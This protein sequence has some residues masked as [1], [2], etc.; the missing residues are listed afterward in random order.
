ML[1]QCQEVPE[2]NKA[3]R[4]RQHIIIQLMKEHSCL[5]FDIIHMEASARPCSDNRKSFSQIEVTTMVPSQPWLQEG[6]ICTTT[7]I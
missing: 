5:M 4:F 2:E 3:S 6:S 1:V 7:K